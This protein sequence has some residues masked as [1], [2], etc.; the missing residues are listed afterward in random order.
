MIFKIDNPKL[1]DSVFKITYYG[2]QF[3]EGQIQ[4]VPESVNTEFNRI[5]KKLSSLIADDT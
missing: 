4:R 3:T 2:R 1:F 5:A